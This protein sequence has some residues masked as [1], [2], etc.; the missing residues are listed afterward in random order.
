[1][2]S[3]YCLTQVTRCYCCFPFFFFVFSSLLLRSIFAED[4]GCE[5][6]ARLVY[7]IFFSFFFFSGPRR[8]CHSVAVSFFLLPDSANF[9]LRRFSRR[10]TVPPLGAFV[11]PRSCCGRRRRFFPPLHFISFFCN[12]TWEGKWRFSRDVFSYLKKKGGRR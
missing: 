8:F 7:S 3:P 1:M 12:H 11:P 10:S 6:G 5:G 2:Y 9:H 4:R